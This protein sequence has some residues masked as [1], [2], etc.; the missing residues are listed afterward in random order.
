MTTTQL[1]IAVAVVLVIGGCLIYASNFFLDKRKQKTLSDLA[2][3]LAR[4]NATSTEKK[5]KADLDAA[6]TTAD[7]SVSKADEDARKEVERASGVN[8]L[9]KYFRDSAR[10]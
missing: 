1:V 10:K 4:K 6:E 5:V 8:G 7:S 2:G 3:D 9:V